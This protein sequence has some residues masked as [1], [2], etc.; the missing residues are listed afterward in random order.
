MTLLEHHTIFFQT[1]KWKKHKKKKSEENRDL[2]G[3]N[4][5]NNDKGLMSEASWPIVRPRRQM[6]YKLKQS[7]M[8]QNG[9]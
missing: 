1:K 5:N 7:E 6:L 4:H 3:E 8:I 2:V 9:S